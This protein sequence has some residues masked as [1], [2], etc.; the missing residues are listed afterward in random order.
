MLKPGVEKKTKYLN[1]K[2]SGLSRK[3][4][5]LEVK[6]KKLSKILNSPVERKKV[7]DKF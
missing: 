4:I 3:I 1:L 2:P 5:F 6:C 7:T